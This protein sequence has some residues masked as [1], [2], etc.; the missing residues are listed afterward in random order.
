[1]LAIGIKRVE[2]EFKRGSVVAIVDPDGHEVARGLTN[3]TSGEIQKITGLSSNKIAEVLGHRPYES[4]VH[5]D[6]MAVQTGDD[7]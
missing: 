7:Q 5:R 6:N 3:Y 1:M 2:G 4:V